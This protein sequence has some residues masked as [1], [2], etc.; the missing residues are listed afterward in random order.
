M[1]F[2]S[3]HHQSSLQDTPSNTPP[4]LLLVRPLPTDTPGR[5]P[6]LH[7]GAPL[8]RQQVSTRHLCA[9]GHY[10]NVWNVYCVH[11]PGVGLHVH[12]YYI[13]YT[14]IERVLQCTTLLHCV[15]SSSIFSIIQKHSLL[16]ICYTFICNDCGIKLVTWYLICEWG[17]LYLDIE[18]DLCT[19]PSLVLWSFHMNPVL[20]LLLKLR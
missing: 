7:Q 18:T 1:W 20:S 9:Y 11:V 12:V 15:L 3:V 17:L 5:P 13:L 19:I 14:C 8:P 10:S 2:Y 16:S 6:L 4:H